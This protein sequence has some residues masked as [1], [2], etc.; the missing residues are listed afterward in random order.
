MDGPLSWGVYYSWIYLDSTY[1]NISIFQYLWKKA[2]LDRKIPIP[3]YHAY[4][5][6]EKDLEKDHL[7]KMKS[8]DSK[9]PRTTL[10]RVYEAYKLDYELFGY[11][12]NQVLMLAGYEPLSMI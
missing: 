12:F 7:E 11:N 3:W 4:L 10:I 9:V 5:T 1:I 2:R 6:E 8:A